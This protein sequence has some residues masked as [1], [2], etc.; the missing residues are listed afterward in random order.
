MLN[1]LACTGSFLALMVQGTA[2]ANKKKPTELQC[3]IWGNG[4]Y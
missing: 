3:Y 2:F 1:R 4:Y